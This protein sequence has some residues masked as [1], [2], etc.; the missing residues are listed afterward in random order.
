MPLK[1]RRRCTHSPAHSFLRSKR[2]TRSPPCCQR[3]RRSPSSS[4]PHSPLNRKNCSG[5]HF[6]RQK[7]SNIPEVVIGVSR[8]HVI[9]YPPILPLRRTVSRIYLRIAKLPAYEIF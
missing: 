1:I 9:T 8:R 4:N 3:R 5:L 7:S 2:S 6:G